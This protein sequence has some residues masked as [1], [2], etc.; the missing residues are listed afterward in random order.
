VTSIQAPPDPA[1]VVDQRAASLGRPLLVSLIGL[2][3]VVVAI[4]VW[5]LFGRVPQTVSGFGY[6][7]P[8]QGFT[9]VGTRLN[10]IVE[11][12][13]VQPGQRVRQGEELIRVDIE[14]GDVES[15]R[16]PV[17][18]IVTEVVAISGRITE[19]GDPMVYLQPADAALVVKTFI[20]VRDSYTINVGAPAAMS[21]A[22][23][24][25]A[26]QYGVIRGTVIDLSPTPVSAERI[27]YIVGGN[28]SLVDYFLASGPVVEVTVELLQDP[29]TPSGY[30]WSIGQGPDVE[31]NAG[32]LSTVTVLL[33]DSSVLGGSTP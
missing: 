2:C 28:A 10:G 22:V 6:V 7:V 29:S 3:L 19:A 14:G 24:P 18:A 9:E 31:I 15:I 26:A 23:A 17:D 16:S 1:A 5:A 25:R 30:S 32:S 8:A 27:N 21:P 20:A 13:G 33:R 12:V 11:T 4:V